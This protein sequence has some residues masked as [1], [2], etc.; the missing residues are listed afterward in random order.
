MAR[1]PGNIRRRISFDAGTYAA[2]DRLARDRMASLQELADEAFRDLLKK[3]RR[4]TTL[5]EMLRQSVRAHP[6]NDAACA[7][8][9]IGQVRHF[10][11]GAGLFSICA[12]RPT[13]F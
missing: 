3:H 5:K 6:A 1:D 11:R 2:L 12:G 4:P 9:E 13:G 7:R 10:P 8:Q